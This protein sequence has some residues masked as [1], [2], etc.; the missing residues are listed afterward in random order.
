MQQLLVAGPRAVR[1]PESLRELKGIII[2]RLV[3]FSPGR[4][5]VVA[6]DT[7]TGQIAW[8]W[9]F[10]RNTPVKRFSAGLGL[11]SHVR[12]SHEAREAIANRNLRMLSEP[13][14]DR[15]LLF[16]ESGECGQFI[17]IIRSIPKPIEIIR[18]LA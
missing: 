1:G 12:I 2:D 8:E 14:L 11:S 15:A 6:Q 9:A 16:T 7:L 13:F 17:E 5:L 18:V 4:E 3:K 10:H